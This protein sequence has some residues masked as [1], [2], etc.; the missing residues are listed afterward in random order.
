MTIVALSRGPKLACDATCVDASCSS[1]VKQ[2]SIKP[3]SATEKAVLKQRNSCRTAIRNYWLVAFAV[4]LLRVCS[5]EAKM[6]SK[7]LGRR[8][9][10]LS[11]PNE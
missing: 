4:D 3:G 8:I 11:S 10:N 1:N 2:S 9:F 6:F 7:D 5:K